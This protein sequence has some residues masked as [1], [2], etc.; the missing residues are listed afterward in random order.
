M[1]AHLQSSRNIVLR[2]KMFASALVMILVASA[3]FSLIIDMVEDDDSGVS[4]NELKNSNVVKQ[5]T[6]HSTTLFDYENGGF[7]Y[8][9]NYWW[10]MEGDYNITSTDMDGDGYSDVND[11]HPLDPAIPIQTHISSNYKCTIG[12]LF[13][14]DENIGLPYSADED[15]ESQ[16]SGLTESMIKWGDIDNDGDLDLVRVSR[17]INSG[18][19]K[20]IA[21][22]DINND[23]FLDVVTTGLGET[24]LYLNHQ[25][26]FSSKIDV[27]LTTDR[28]LSTTPNTQF[29]GVN[30][31]WTYSFAAYNDIEIGDLDGDGD[32]DLALASN[33]EIRIIDNTGFSFAS[34][35]LWTN[36]YSSPI[37][38]ELGD[39][40]NDG[41]LDLAVGYN[42]A[43]VRVYENNNGF[44]T[45]AYWESNSDYLRAQVKWGDID[46]NNFL[47]LVVGSNTYNVIF[48]NSVFFGLNTNPTWASPDSEMT[49]DI[50]LGDLDF[51]GDLD[52]FVINHESEA[53]I[54]KNSG[55]TLAASL[56]WKS[57]YQEAAYSSSLADIDGDGGLD[58]S[59]GGESIIIH[60]SKGG[61]VSTSSD[62]S[63][64]SASTASYFAVGD[65]NND[66]YLDLVSNSGNI[67][68]YYN[69]NG[70]GYNNS[71]DW[72]SNVHTKALALED[73]DN[74]GD[75]D[76]VAS[77][78]GVSYV[79]Q[80][81]GGQFSNTSR[82]SFA[83]ISISVTTLAIGD[84]DNNGYLDVLIGGNSGTAVNVFFNTGGNLNNSADLTIGPV[85]TYDVKVADMDNN[86]YLDVVIANVSH[87]SIDIY[88]NSNGIIST[89]NPAT[90]TLAFPKYFDL[91]DMDGD[92]DLDIVVAGKYDS[93]NQKSRVYEN[94]NSNFA[95]AMI[96]NESG[97]SQDIDWIDFDGD[98][99]LDIVEIIGSDSIYAYNNHEGVI[100]STSYWQSVGNIDPITITPSDVNADGIIDLIVGQINI[101]TTIYLSKQD[102]DRDGIQDWEDVF[103]NDPTQYFDG[104][105]DGFGDNA[106]GRLNDGCTGYWGDSW[107][108]RWGC[109]DEDGDGQSNLNDD[110]WNKASQW[111]DTDGDGLGDNWG[112]VSWNG[113]RG[114]AWPGEFFQFAFNADPSPLDYDNDG[115]EDWG[116]SQ[117]GAI[118]PYDA[119]P[120]NYGLSIMDK[121]GC[122]DSDGDGWSDEGDSHIGDG[123]QH[124]DMDND[125]YGDNSSGNLA[126]SCPSVWGNST[127]DVYGCI[128]AD[129][130]GVSG[131]S[132][133]DDNDAGEFSDVDGDGHGD[134]ADQCKFIWGNITEG[135]DL[136]CPDTDGDG[137]ADQNDDLP[138]EPT[139][140]LDEDG[141]GYG[142]NQ[143]GLYPDACI[144]VVGSSV[145]SVMQ[146]GANESKFG[147]PDT[148]GDKYEDLSDPC[149][150]EFGNS[151]VDRL[152]CPDSDQDGISDSNDPY[153]DVPAPSN[154]DWDGDGVPDINDDFPS[155]TTQHSDIDGDNY[156]DNIEGN[157]PDLFINDPS[158]WADFDLDGYG[159]NQSVGA[160]QPDACV[161]EH[162]NSSDAATGFG[163][164]DSDGDGIGDR[165]D[166]F[167]DEPSQWVDED[168]DGYGDNPDGVNGDSCAH[169][170]GTSYLGLLGCPDSDRDGWS[171]IVDAFD[172]DPTQYADV[173]NDGY[174]D[175]PVGYNADDCLNE[176][177]SSSQGDVLGCIDTDADGWADIVDVYP[178]SALTWSDVDGDGFADQLGENNSDDCPGVPGLSTEYMRGCPDFDQDGLPDLFDEDIDGDNISNSL[179]IQ[180]AFDPWDGENVP[181]DN[182]NDGIPDMIDLDDDNDGFPDEIEEERGSDPF[183]ASEDPFNLYGSGMG[184]YY[185]PNDGFSY[186]YS[187]DGFEFSLSMLITIVSSELIVPLLLLPPTIIF[188]RRK[189]IRYNM[190]E[191]KLESAETLEEVDECEVEID[192]MLHNQ[193]IKIEKGIIL[194]NIAT[195]K[196]EILRD[197]GVL[198]SK[199]SS[200]DGQLDIKEIAEIGPVVDDIANDIETNELL[201]EEAEI[202][203]VE[204]MPKTQIDEE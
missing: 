80:N 60:F 204:E 41:D 47:D 98:G 38:I 92:G 76:L 158:Q 24:E 176:S 203:G 173:D 73:M 118:G 30:A 88:Y 110:F 178:N 107:R 104:D 134:S 25:G 50:S 138:L 62:W 145:L 165:W 28:V 137:W 27:F 146:N 97:F 163:C 1:V 188:A 36:N 189:K 85:Q 193:K 18:Y 63:S 131:I 11:S 117:D 37:S 46:G 13:C 70:D 75:V 5:N 111:Q 147:C 100:S 54:F 156:G 69:N 196:R 2:K 179:E 15:W 52:L 113:S 81:Q 144:V 58:L 84:I 124:T 141:D 78:S 140:W 183:D 61:V 91:G 94:N 123:T 31:N 65:V 19:Q 87:D 197:E 33:D 17:T 7:H 112:N 164:I 16:E 99:D 129:G 29:A 191:S 53:Q 159:D 142:D 86:G 128:D 168:N 64:N 198:P 122:I 108:D 103:D 72:V 101:N 68:L 40:D 6:S 132:D 106:I 22:G 109:Q 39:K 199:Y 153:P 180:I 154:S 105:G 192:Q 120:L 152:G 55:S 59:I 162:G 93:S 121:N 10:G 201:S 32:L 42:N 187:E 195:R 77:K 49:T 148:D 136:G 185:S 56:S 90:I 34:S 67:E 155:D 114:I 20:N 3:I 126:D 43:K 57:S 149:P 160:N 157:S 177:G 45:S 96:L 9:E 26:K 21:L 143:S 166:D 151:W 89:T 200:S 174:G 182:D 125:G 169:Q 115:F 95:L 74:D 130:D 175:S 181:D 8:V 66:G 48:F 82:T 83:T 167:T 23:G 184:F 51:D 135:D 71:P 139:Q 35:P 12:D 119:C 14:L 190:M 150:F 133:F 170:F 102:I 116:L 44:S 172:T 202:K 4:N 127:I 186:G 161:A 171:D 194:S 79:Y